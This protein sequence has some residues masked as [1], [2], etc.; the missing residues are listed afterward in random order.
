MSATLTAGDQQSAHQVFLHEQE[1]LLN[2]YS[3]A[4]HSY[5][6]AVMELDEA[7]KD[8]ILGAYWTLLA[9]ADAAKHALEHCRDRYQNY[10]AL[11]DTV[12]N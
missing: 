6:N 9:K 10:C 1:H 7:R 2:E 4:V 11:K 12:D 3:R 5:Q 8:S